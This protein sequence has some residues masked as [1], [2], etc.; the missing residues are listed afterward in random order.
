M[1]FYLENTE[2]VDTFAELFSAYYARVL[3]TAD[4]EKWALAAAQA[5]TGFGTSIIMSPAEA[6]IEKFIEA[7]KTPDGRPGYVIQIWHVKKD[8]LEEQLLKRISQCTMTCPTTAVFNYL[9]S[10]ER[11]P[12]G[13]KIRYFGDGYEK[14]RKI[15]G[16]KMWSIPVMDGEFL[17][18][19]EF[20]IAE[21]V[22]GG[23]F[24]LLGERRED[25]LKSAELAIEA[26]SNLEGVIT[27][28][29]G[30][31][32]RSGSKVGSLKYKFL[33]ASTNHLYCPVLPSEV[34]SPYMNGVNAVYEIVINGVNLEAVKKAIGLGILAAVKGEIKRI[35]AAN[36]DGKLGKY[37]VKLIDA[38]KEVGGK[39]H[40]VK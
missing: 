37:Q 6:G 5:T 30:G 26:L 39:I 27:P 23:N 11:I 21:G 18:E 13:S 12:V 4:N 16:R 40:E 20:S 19:N 14:K 32:C 17:I 8:K 36:F 10:G 28:F 3:I 7:E 25:A 34:K 31:I 9:D 33:K 29:P 1:R 22:S 24:L 2:I 38:V 15:A 35:S